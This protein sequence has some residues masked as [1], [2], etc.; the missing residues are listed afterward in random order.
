MGHTVSNAMM[1]EDMPL[2]KEKK[3]KPLP[4]GG[5]KKILREER[6]IGRMS[7]LQIWVYQLYKHR[8]FLTGVT[9]GVLLPYGLHYGV[10]WL[11]KTIH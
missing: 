10:M 2:E 11:E 4:K 7:D 5:V 8:V 3:V 1:F 9:M 6:P